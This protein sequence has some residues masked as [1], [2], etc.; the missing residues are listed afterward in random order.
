[1]QT[2]IWLTKFGWQI[3]CLRGLTACQ[4]ATQATACAELARIARRTAYAPFRHAPPAARRLAAARLDAGIDAVDDQAGVRMLQGYKPQATCSPQM[5]YAQPTAAFAR[6]FYAPWRLSSTFF[7]RLSCPYTSG[8]KYSL[9][10]SPTT[11][12]K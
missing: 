6:N 8:K 10:F 3:K 2:D 5:S 7:R 11:V 1:M 12:V 4:P 9:P